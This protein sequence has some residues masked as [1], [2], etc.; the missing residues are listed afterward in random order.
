MP[1]PTDL[2]SAADAPVGSL[3]TLLSGVGISEPE[4]LGYT[5]LTNPNVSSHQ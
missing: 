5:R 4:C 1:G 2:W 3:W